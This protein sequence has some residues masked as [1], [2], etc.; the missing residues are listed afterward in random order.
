MA[1]AHSKNAIFKMHIPILQANYECRVVKDAANYK[2][3][4]LEEYEITSHEQVLENANSALAIFCMLGLLES[5]LR[6]VKA[7]K[8]KK[9]VY[10]QS[11]VVFIS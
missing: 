1:Q 10:T 4:S 5:T 3:T 9:P 8:Q 11:M 6:R 7:Q 2:H